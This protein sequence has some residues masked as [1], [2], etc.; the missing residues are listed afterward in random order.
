MEMT[1]FVLW[2]IFAIA[3]PLGFVVSGHFA[4]VRGTRALEIIARTACA[5]VIYGIT[6]VVLMFPMFLMVFTELTAALS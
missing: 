2:C 1:I 3:I 6:S 5:L 4:F